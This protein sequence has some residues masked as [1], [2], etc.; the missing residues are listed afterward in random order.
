MHA[1]YSLPYRHDPWIIAKPNSWRDKEKIDNLLSQLNNEKHRILLYLSKDL[2]DENDGSV[3]K[4]WS[5]LVEIQRIFYLPGVFK[6]VK[7]V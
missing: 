5:N 4:L 1:W 2:A 7:E 3:Y 6:N